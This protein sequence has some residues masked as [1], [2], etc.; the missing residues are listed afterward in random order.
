[1]TNP[2]MSEV[3]KPAEE[4]H[5]V[6]ADS[7]SI[8]ELKEGMTALLP[9]ISAAGKRCRTNYTQRTLGVCAPSGHIAGHIT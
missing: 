2:G 3:T 8:E 1:V 9:K 4:P 6:V 7:V 5:D